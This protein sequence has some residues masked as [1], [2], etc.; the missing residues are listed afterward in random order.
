MNY[1]S[2]YKRLLA[3]RRVWTRA[4]ILCDECP[5]PREP[6]VYAWYFR[7]IPPSVPVADCHRH[8]EL[9]LLYVGISPKRPPQNGG[10]ASGQR[11]WHRVRY[12]YRG[13]AEGSTLRLTL[14]C[15]LSEQLAIDLRRVGS[16]KRR[17]FADGEQALSDWMATNAVVVWAEAERPWELE[18]QLIRSL[19]LPLNLQGNAA[20]VFHSRL[21]EL[22]RA[23]R[24][25]ADSLPVWQAL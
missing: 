16:G 6:G 8:N 15:L 20:H 12:H 9:N 19:S 25:R 18:E 10:Q 22:R 24:Q 2:A 7:G 4:D 21:S 11:L 3:P 23:S 14:G 17:T 1:L 5:V 13:N